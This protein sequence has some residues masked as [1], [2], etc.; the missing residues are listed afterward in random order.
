MSIN[1]EKMNQGS[2]LILLPDHFKAQLPQKVYFVFTTESYKKST[3]L[4]QIIVASNVED[5]MFYQ[6]LDDF[7]QNQRMEDDC[8]GKYYYIADLKNVR[9]FSEYKFKKYQKVFAF[10]DDK[11]DSAGKMLKWFYPLDEK[12]SIVETKYYQNIKKIPQLYL[13]RFYLNI[14]IMRIGGLI[15]RI[16]FY[17]MVFIFDLFK[18]TF[19]KYIRYRKTLNSL[20]SEPDYFMMG[21]YGSSEKD[22]ALEKEK[23]RK[24]HA[25]A[26]KEYLNSNIAVL[27]LIF[28]VVFFSITQCYNNI[29][30][31]KKNNNIVILDK[32]TEP[33]PTPIPQQRYP[34]SLQG[35]MIGDSMPDELK[36]MIQENEARKQ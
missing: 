25:E 4:A 31:L 32:N 6:T 29:T 27:T 28:S 34:T 24:E 14:I 7:W 35:C 23:R 19:E 15:K 10:I 21:L 12:K 33:Q 8:K 3:H 5:A 16:A 11:K 2:P 13:I 18:L 26:K 1:F 20:N 30:V 22:I 36:R 17:P 9:S